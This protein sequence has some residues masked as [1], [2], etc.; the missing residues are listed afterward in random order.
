MMLLEAL[1]DPRTWRFSD[2][3]RC[4]LSQGAIR[5]LTLPEFG[6]PSGL[7]LRDGHTR[8]IFCRG[9]ANGRLER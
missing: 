6:L 4:L 1:N 7:T 8:A 5:F 3:E 9:T 2:L